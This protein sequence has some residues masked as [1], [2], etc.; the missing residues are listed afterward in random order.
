MTKKHKILIIGDHL[1]P[2][3]AQRQL[4]YLLKNVDR[5][6]FKVYL[7]LFNKAG[8]GLNDIPKDIEIYHL[9]EEEIDQTRNRKPLSTAYRL[10]KTLVKLI[11]LQIKV[12]YDFLY[13]NLFGPNILVCIIKLIFGSKPKVIISV[14]N[15]PNKVGAVKRSLIR[16]L[17]PKADSV[18]ACATGLKPILINKYKI[19]EDK[20]S[21]V[22]N[23]VNPDFITKRSKEAVAHDWF[24]DDIPVLISV[25][26]L[27]PQKG[28]PY[29]IKSFK[30]VLEHK[31]ARLLI[32]GEGVERGILEKMV[33]DYQINDYVEFLG[34][35]SNTN[36]YVAKSTIFVLPSLWE[37]LATVLLEA[38][39]VKTPLVATDAPFGSSDVVK[40]N[41]T[42]LLVPIKNSELL[43][44]AIIKI[45]DKSEL[46]NEFV[47]NAYNHIQDTFS[48]IAITKKLEEIA[49]SL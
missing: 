49:L 17:Y 41:K 23:A 33:A 1:G 21:I 8:D 39:I 16:M 43:A 31:K 6:R 5:K 22:F 28:Y 24:N 34:V 48:D 9:L 36:K 15:N 47:E 18:L 32:I 3:G 25:A 46:R 2:A 38:A 27:R 26:H 44:E 20:I 29:L 14:V 11:H 19:P 42:G 40:N 30:S 35:V 10:L 13:G 12:R 45:L 4:I 37:G 7:F